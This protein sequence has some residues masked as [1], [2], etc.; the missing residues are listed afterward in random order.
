[1]R[2]SVW[3]VG[4][5]LSREAPHEIW[6][7]GRRRV[8]LPSRRRAAPRRAAPRRRDD[9]ARQELE[10]HR[11]GVRDD[12]GGLQ[13]LQH[14]RHEVRDDAELRRQEGGGSGRVR[15]RLLGPQRRD[16]EAGGDQ[17]DPEGVRGHHR[18]QAAAARDQD[19]QALQARQRAR[20]RRH[21]RAAERER[22]G[23]EGRV[24]RLRADG[25]RPPLHHPLEAAADRRALQVL[26]VPDPPRRPRDP[27]GAR[28]PPRPQA[29]QPPRQQELRPQDLRLRPRAADQPRGR[30]EGPRPHRVRRD[31]VVPRARAPRREPG[32]HDGDRRVGGAPRN[33][34][35]QIRPLNSGANIPRKYS[36]QFR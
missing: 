34:A 24:H 22:E 5:L 11:A 32:L 33:S 23:V 18:L 36:A 19:P 8:H 35:S 12:R 25:H 31:A 27:P 15:P 20:P 10:G 1:M 6:L 2:C 26:P 28:P 13:A 9:G 7:I 30:G 16:V 21:P 14:V 3:R 17:E 29:G 4:F